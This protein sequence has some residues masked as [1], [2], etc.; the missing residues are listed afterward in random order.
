MTTEGPA[1]PKLIRSLSRGLYI[2][3]MLNRGE[4]LSL[5]QIAHGA[6]VPYA[7]AVRFVQ[8]LLHSGMIEREPTRKRYRV[9]ALVQSLSQGF[10]NPNRL[11]IAAGPHIR[12]LTERF[13]WPITVTTRVGPSMIIRDSTHGLTSM[14]FN[15]YQPGYIFPILEASSGRVYLAFC[16]EA[17]RKTVLMGLRGDPATIGRE[18]LP[19]FESGAMVEQIRQD[20]YATKGRN[21][22]TEHPGKTSSIAVPVFDAGHIAGAITLTFFASALSMDQA[23]ERFCGPLKA[24]AHIIGQAMEDPLGGE[25]HIADLVSSHSE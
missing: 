5:T 2:L 1:P 21:L 15:N 25:A 9:T 24:T 13:G 11:V 4:P 19:L 22:Y 17:E 16:D 23:V 14:T 12:A 7:T 6:G 3:Q 10:Q 20:G 8:T 18:L